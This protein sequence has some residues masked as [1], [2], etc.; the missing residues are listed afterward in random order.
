[1]DSAGWDTRYRA[2]E[3]VWGGEPNRFVAEE[4]TGT[5][6]GRVDVTGFEAGVGDPHP[7]HV[8]GQG[9]LG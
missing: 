5:P 2:S 8:Q 9:E 7:Q 1:M 6:P 4:L 3:L